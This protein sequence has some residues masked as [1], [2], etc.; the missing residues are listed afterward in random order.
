MNADSA[1]AMLEFSSVADGTRVA[2]AMVKRAPIT[3]FTI[4]TVQ[5]GKYLV[6]VGGSVAAV[7]EAYIEGMRLSGATLNDEVFLPDAHEQ[8]QDAIAGVRILASGD[9]LG[10]I[11]TSTIPSVLRAADRAVKHAN[12]DIVEIRFGDG[13]G[14][15]G[16]VHL[17]GRVHD[18]EA[19]I[20]AVITS[21]QRPGLELR[22]CVIAAQDVELQARI[23][24]ATEFRP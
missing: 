22:S 13:L 18:V 7:E 17:C 16:L 14:G 3:L 11:E 2:D 23:N 9:A 4:G 21:A 5:P 15:K 10:V 24:R 6:L 20:D 1:L 19:A 8:V 12:I